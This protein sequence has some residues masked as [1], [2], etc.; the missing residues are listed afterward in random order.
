MKNNNNRWLASSSLLS[1]SSRSA[2]VPRRAE[3]ICWADRVTILLFLLSV[4]LSLSI[5]FRWW[6]EKTLWC[7]GMPLNPSLTVWWACVHY[8]LRVPAGWRSSEKKTVI[9]GLKIERFART[10]LIMRDYVFI[11]EIYL[12]WMQ[13]RMG[14]ART[15]REGQ[16]P[17]TPV[18]DS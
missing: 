14:V 2:L 12:H 17:F 13:R 4:Y 1:I 9:N 8:W 7:I 15:H 11:T 18:T 3:C 10:R 6:I 5:T 16:K